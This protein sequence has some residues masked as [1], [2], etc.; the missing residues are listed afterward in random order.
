M[1]GTV[2]LEHV[3]MRTCAPLT[4]TAPVLLGEE[5]AAALAGA[6]HHKLAALGGD[7]APRHEHVLVTDEPVAPLYAPAELLPLLG[8]FADAL[9]RDAAAPLD[10]DRVLRGGDHRSLPVEQHFL[11]VALKVL[12]HKG[13]RQHGD[14]LGVSEAATTVHALRVVH[15]VEKEALDASLAACVL[16]RAAG[17][18]ACGREP[19]VAADGACGGHARACR[20]DPSVNKSE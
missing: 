6:A 18:G 10:C 2:L 4:H 12:V 3:A 9:Q 11:A 19:H 13:A 5:A 1:V 20:R 17:D 8:P 7:F 16:T 15:R 14:Q